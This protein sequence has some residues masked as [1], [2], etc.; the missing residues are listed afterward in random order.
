M[1]TGCRNTVNVMAGHTQFAVVAI[2]LSR[3]DVVDFL[4]PPQPEARGTAVQ[5]VG[6]RPTAR[7]EAAWVARLKQ[8]P[9]PSVAALLAIDNPHTHLITTHTDRLVPVQFLLAEHNFL[10]RDLG[11]WVSN[12]FGTLGLGA[13]TPDD[14]L[15]NHAE[16]LQTYG[17][18][19][20]YFGAD[21]AQVAERLE[22]ETGLPTAELTAAICQLHQLRAR[23]LGD[24]PDC[25]AHMR[26]VERVYE[27]IRSHNF[28]A[29]VT[30]TGE[31]DRQAALPDVL[32]YDELMG[33]LVVIEQ[34]RRDAQA[35]FDDV[36]AAHLADWQ[37]RQ[38][39]EH[40]LELLLKGEYIVGRHR[41]S[42][43]LIAPELG[44]VVKQPAPE[45][46]HEI[47]LGARIALGRPENWPYLTHDGSLVTARGRVRLILEEDLVPR[48]SAAFDYGMRF[49]SLLGLT[50]EQF[51]QGKTVQEV[52][53]GDHTRLNATLYEEIVLHQQV[54][55]RLGIENG[56]WHA[57]NFVVRESD[58]EVVHVDW[59][60]ARPLR[61]DEFTPGAVRG[62]I[63]QVSNM[64]YS[65]KDEGL[66]ARLLGLHRDLT[67][68]EA[69]M[70]R[71]RGRAEQLA[72]SA[73]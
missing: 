64:A 35:R 55:E 51:V 67:G 11:G 52:V 22:A 44:V 6:Q 43:I 59:G 71:L 58:G 37:S 69:Q 62:R 33:Q 4:T 13:N 19:I 68:D 47:E 7:A 21:E 24:A 25:A 31:I 49:S 46:F 23:F 5:I 42:T 27:E 53:L 17:D 39:A 54:C 72:R 66:A 41:R 15:L 20:A 32:L 56:D 38:L 9:R 60:A 18:E 45:P 61:S 34:A 10:T 50:I 28:F 70:M 8:Q 29:G 12:Y 1:A 14:P 40:G 26:Y 57:P 16:V 30:A 2:P 48:I 73:V 65:F 3:P 36:Q 63:D